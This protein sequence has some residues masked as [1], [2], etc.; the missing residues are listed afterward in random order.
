M[1]HGNL[2][3][4]MRPMRR[5]DRQIV[6]E[7]QL[8]DILRSAVV[9]RIAFCDE[10]WPYIV[11]MNFGCL[12]GK[13]YFHSAMSGLKLDLLKANANVCFEVDT[14]VEILPGAE[15]CGWSARFRSVIGFG[16]ISLVE[17]PEE[18]RAGIRALVAQYTD[19]KIDAPA[20][21]PA[22]TVVLRLDVHQLTGKQSTGD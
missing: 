1:M 2:P 19:R 11:P 10:N 15:A 22:S 8:W 20:V 4:W 13:L 17:D 12:D 14:D 3:S 5:Q 21:I 7:A 6:D 16:R 9:C 18:K